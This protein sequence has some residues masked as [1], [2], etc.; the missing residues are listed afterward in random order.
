MMSMLI[1]FGIECIFSTDM[2]TAYMQIKLKDG[3]EKYLLSPEHF[4]DKEGNFIPHGHLLKTKVAV[5][6]FFD[7]AKLLY[8]ALSGVLLQ[9]GFK[10]NRHEHGLF[11][12]LVDDQ[13]I[14]C[15]L[16]VD[17]NIVACSKIS[18]AE[19][20][21]KLFNKAGYTLSGKFFPSRHLGYRIRYYRT[22][23]DRLAMA[24]D[25]NEYA[26]ILVDQNKHRLKT[27]RKKYTLPSD[28]SIS[29]LNFE[30]AHKDLEQDFSEKEIKT[31]R[32]FVGAALYLCGKDRPTLSSTVNLLARF[33]TKPTE[34]WNEVAGHSIG[35]LRQDLERDPCILFCPREKGDPLMPFICGLTDAG[36]K[37]TFNGRA[38]IGHLIFVG[39]GEKWSLVSWLCA[40]TKTANLSSTDSE[41]YGM[42]AVTCAILG[43][44]NIL[45]NEGL[46][47]LTFIGEDNKACLLNTITGKVL[48]YLG[49]REN[50]THDVL[51]AGYIEKVLKINGFANLSDLQ[52][53]RT[54][55]AKDFKWM[56]SEI[57][58]SRDAKFY[59]RFTEIDQSLYD[60]PILV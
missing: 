17:D 8:E 19:Y 16:Y 3:N 33:Q 21:L 14:V 41:T 5:Y 58:I 20:V 12:K 35:W 26:Q 29:D 30:I 11:T 39:Y 40:L 44:L 13:W 49:Y 2:D 23:S 48:G 60:K 34:Q 50:H 43:I 24:L 10:K 57:T 9:N 6:G 55:K 25:C 18:D 52:S 46:S 37:H 27:T 42:S 1:W 56:N 45:M 31:A 54:K 7:S 47:L 32:G 15:L 4:T 36:W 59:S 38:L 22:K 28:T 51:R 53:K